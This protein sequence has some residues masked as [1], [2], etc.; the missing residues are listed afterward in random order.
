MLGFE[1][2]PCS[3]NAWEVHGALKALYFLKNEVHGALSAH[4]LGESLYEK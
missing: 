2:K 4:K 3:L 1:A